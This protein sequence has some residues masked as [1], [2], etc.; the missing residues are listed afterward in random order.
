[1]GGGEVCTV[2]DIKEEMSGNVEV[3]VVVVAA[4][5][6]QTGIEV[7]VNTG[8]VEATGTGMSESKS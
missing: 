7:R 6:D 2:V 4:S 1:M 3:D 5:H 8:D